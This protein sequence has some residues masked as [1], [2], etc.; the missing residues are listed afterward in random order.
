[1]IA[2]FQRGKVKLLV[3][4]PQLADGNDPAGVHGLDVD[5]LARNMAILGGV[6]ATDDE[7]RNVWRE[8]VFVDAAKL[9]N[10]LGNVRL[11]G[12]VEFC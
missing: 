9:G 4:F 1:M 6:V 3:L 7:M 10:F 11:L 8:I 2:L 5:S 12:R